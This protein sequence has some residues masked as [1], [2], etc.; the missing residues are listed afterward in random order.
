MN[1]HVKTTIT[2]PIP[3]LSMKSVMREKYM[4]FSQFPY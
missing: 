4:Q 2:L 1:V 3:G